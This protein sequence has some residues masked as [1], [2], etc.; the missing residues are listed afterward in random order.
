MGQEVEGAEG[1]ERG[2]SV[3]L[4]ISLRPSSQAWQRIVSL[5]GGIVLMSDPPLAISLPNPL[6]SLCLGAAGEKKGPQRRPEARK[7]RCLRLTRSV[8]VL[9]RGGN[10]GFTLHPMFTFSY[11]CGE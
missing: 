1:E 10:L 4:M 9:I 11:A 3:F 5:L 8:I 2:Q 7:Q 6:L